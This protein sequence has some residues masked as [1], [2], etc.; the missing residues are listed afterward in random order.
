M[1]W[2]DFAVQFADAQWNRT[3]GNSR[4]NTAKALTATTVAM[5]RTPPAGFK[6][7]DVRTALREFAFNTRAAR[8][9]A[10][11]RYP[12]SCRWVERN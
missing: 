2:Y 8:G 5:L 7:V 4:K 10:P 11:A 9:G 6:P 12:P 3:A 1:N